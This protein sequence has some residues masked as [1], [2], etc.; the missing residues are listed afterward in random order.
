[1]NL[2]AL[3]GSGGMNVYVSDSSEASA[4]LSSLNAKELRST[5]WSIMYEVGLSEFVLDNSTGLVSE[6]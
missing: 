2:Y 6:L 5:G 4:L 3:R 1:M